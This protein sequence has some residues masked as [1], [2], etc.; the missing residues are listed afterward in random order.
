MPTERPASQ[1][2]V[3]LF[4]R[5]S[6]RERLPKDVFDQLMGVIEGTQKLE[7]SSAGVI[8]A[9]MKEWAVSRGATHYT[10]W[11]HPRTE[12]TAEKHM[13]FLTVDPEGLPLEAF[14]A[15]E[16][17][18][19]EPDASSFPSGGVRSTF[20]ARGY[21][22]WD[23]TSPAFVVSSDRGGT[24]CIPS[25]FIAYD[26]TPL[27]MKT[28]LLKALGAVESR[29][30]RI[31]R[32]FGNR[33]VKWI[34]MMAGAEQE[35]FLLD[36]DRARQRP[37][38]LFCGH[39]LQG[40][41]PPKGQQMEDH[42]FG[43]IHHRALA[44]MEEAEQELA[45]LGV[46]VKTRHNEV[47]PCQLEFAPQ[48][49][50]A[51]LACDQNQIMML[52]MRRLAHRHGLRLLLHE[53]PFAGLNGSGKHVNFSLMDSEGRNLLS[54]SGN[55]R[56]NVQ[57]LTYLCAFLLGLQRYGGL[58][59]ASIACP[60]NMWR[61]GGNEAPPVIMSVYLGDLLTRILEQIEQGAP[62][63]IPGRTLL[64]LGLNRLP[65]IKADN[66]DR[67]RTAPIAFTGNKL[68]FRAPG[69]SQSIAGPL[70]VLAAVWCWGM[71]QM[72]SRIEARMAAGG[73]DAADAALEAIQA[74][75]RET[76]GVRFEGNCY[77]PE[78]YE[79]AARRDLPIALTTPEALSLFLVPENRALLADLG[80]LSDREIEAY[81]E[82]RLEQYVK[83]ME[84]EMG[85]LQAMTWE[86]IVPAL[87]RQ[88]AEEGA[89]LAP[90]AGLPL[91]LKP[92]QGHLLRLGSLKGEILL[93]L[94]RLEEI[95]GLIREAEGDLETQS[96][97]I[98]ADGLP[99]LEALRDLLDGA[100]Q[101]TGREHWPFPRYR[102]LLS[103]G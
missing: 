100:E 42:Y 77:A 43:S 37:D 18:Q 33:G 34:R 10:H 78:W 62:E 102:E 5:R 59:R 28:P 86:G 72:T 12:M 4:D 52:T 24:L 56:R 81:Y 19:S 45:R 73:T 88:I 23:P 32:L 101:I 97:R 16:L 68:E 83:S 79:E 95:H 82:T 49:A 17:I 44:Y 38:I 74:A 103:L 14:S 20:E 41:A 76:R 31:A 84:I 11:F 39:T 30:M 53:K 64:D 35:F 22:A 91:D 29:A 98:T 75:V 85:I 55:Q 2:A 58:L 63:V 47:A 60:G 40:A 21:T 92:L 65:S 15:G 96:E 51:N 94:E 46:V 99:A 8:A 1:F 7:E 67:N 87:N 27:D 93:A 13:A 9:A 6:M 61:L 54:P 50:E 90:L 66:T 26:G 89:A 25:V 70:T 57:F 69:A 71:D 48:Y 36:G 3:D 80:I